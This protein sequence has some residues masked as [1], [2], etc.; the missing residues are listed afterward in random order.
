ML[1]SSDA[2]QA[3]LAQ[4]NEPHIAP[5]TGLLKSLR[6]EKGE[7]YHIPN[8]DPWDGGVDAEVLFLLEAPGA[9]ARD[10]GF[11]SRN[12]PDET[13]KNMFELNQEAGI[14]RKQSILWNAVPWY[15]GSE[16][17]IRPARADDVAEGLDALSSLV[18]LLPKLKVIALVGKKSQ[19]AESHIR[20]MNPDV[21]VYCCPHPSPLFVNRRPENREILLNAFRSIKNQ[22]EGVV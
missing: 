22:L 21:L 7:G 14:S 17:K 18:K 12:N 2:M 9:K 20:A 4:L 11:I 19:L 10:S 6:K 15:I 5:L 13:A 1:H 3:R 8:F 16:K